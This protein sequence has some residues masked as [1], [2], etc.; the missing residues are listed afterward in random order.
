MLLG[1]PLCAADYWIL[2]L[3]NC[4]N[5]IHDSLQSVYLRHIIY[6]LCLFN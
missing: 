3:K 2:Y 1:G 5:E 6:A 4:I